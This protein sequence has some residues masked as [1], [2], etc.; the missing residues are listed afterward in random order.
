MALKITVGK[1]N[2]NYVEIGFCKDHLVDLLHVKQ[3][4]DHLYDELSES[5]FDE[6][7]IGKANMI[8]HEGE[9]FIITSDNRVFSL[10]AP[11][12]IHDMVQREIEH[13]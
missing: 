6:K 8:V 10:S 12:S 9:K 5:D 7:T 2:S 3:L 13:A 1:N 11:L 4:V